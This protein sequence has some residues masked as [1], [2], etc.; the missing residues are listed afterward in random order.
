M[1]FLNFILPSTVDVMFLPRLEFL[2]RF[3]P[4]SCQFFLFGVDAVLLL[5]DLVEGISWLV[6]TFESFIFL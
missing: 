2:L 1:W 6:N 3:V 5:I 4:C